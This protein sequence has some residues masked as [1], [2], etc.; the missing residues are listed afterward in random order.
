MLLLDARDVLRDRGWCQFQLED[1]NGRVCVNGAIAVAMD[2]DAMGKRIQYGSRFE[3]PWLEAQASLQ[4]ATGV[5]NAWNVPTWNNTPGRTQADVE[6]A[7][8]I[9]ASLSASEAAA[10]REEGGR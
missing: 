9:A 3:K 1:A 7:L 10:S 5:S 6:E 2:G 4:Q 8:E